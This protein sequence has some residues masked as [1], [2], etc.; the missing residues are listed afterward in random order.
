MLTVATATPIAAM[1]ATMAHSTTTASQ[2]GSAQIPHPRTASAH[3]TI[4][5]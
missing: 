2:R 4:K 3:R 1:L 5:W